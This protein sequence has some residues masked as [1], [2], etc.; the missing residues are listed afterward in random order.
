MPPSAVI[1]CC[2]FSP[3]QL[4]AA[5]KDR[6]PIADFG[7]PVFYSLWRLRLVRKVPDFPKSLLSQKFSLPGRASSYVIKVVTPLF[8]GGVDPGENDPHTLIRGTAIRGHLRFWWR[9]TRGARFKDAGELAEEE[10]K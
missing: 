9:A 4:T 2:T 5:E 6:Q 10:G 7:I 8:G 1:K 3:W